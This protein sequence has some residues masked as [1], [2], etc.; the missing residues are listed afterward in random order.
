MTRRAWLCGLVAWAG[1]IASGCG[2]ALAGRGSFLPE[3]IRTIG[4]PPLEN[5]TTVSQ[6]ELVLTEKVRNEFI[7]RGKYVVVPTEA[8]AQAVLSGAITGVTF[9]PV[10]FTAQQ[11][12]SRYLFTMTMRVQFTDATTNE[13]L[14]SNE[15]LTFREE[16]DV[17][18]GG[19]A[20]ALE[21]TALL[22]Q[23]RAT[24][25]RISS[26][27]ARSVVSAILEAF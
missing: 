7:G 26:D 21:A 5:R 6:I 2:Y 22:D 24:F 9:Q 12:G 14:W 11:L 25:E 27:V 23:E 17:S 18:R 19:G 10:G 13:V 15:S 16:Y 1:L 4:I 8:G 3:Y 20:V